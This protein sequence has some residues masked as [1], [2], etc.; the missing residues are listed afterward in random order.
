MKSHVIANK[1]Y[2][3]SGADIPTRPLRF[4]DL[5]PDLGSP[6]FNLSLP[7]LIFQKD[8]LV[9]NKISLK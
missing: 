2:T 3:I 5:P 7:W 8:S 9:V 4:L 6:D 1:E